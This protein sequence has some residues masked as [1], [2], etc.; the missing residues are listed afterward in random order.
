M[1]YHKVKQPRGMTSREAAAMM[2]SDGATKDVALAELIADGKAL[3]P[4]VLTRSHFRRQFGFDFTVEPDPKSLRYI[5]RDAELGLSV[6]CGYEADFNN[7]GA[8]LAKACIKL[9]KL[10]DKKLAETEAQKT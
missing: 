4:D 8:R 7:Q 1:P 2:I 3:D 9:K 10:H 6:T 5:I